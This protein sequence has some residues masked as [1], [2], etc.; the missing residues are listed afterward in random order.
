MTTRA[1]TE[2]VECFA[3]RHIAKHISHRCSLA[4]ASDQYCPQDGPYSARRS[5][6]APGRRCE[7]RSPEVF[8]LDSL[9]RITFEPALAQ[10][11]SQETRQPKSRARVRT[12]TE[13]SA[14]GR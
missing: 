8:H 4:G 1:R 14:G 5:T 13:A 7:A 6:K 11:G 12:P 2:I 10:P 3:R 9:P